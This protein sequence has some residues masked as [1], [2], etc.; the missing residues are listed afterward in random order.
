MGIL[1]RSDGRVRAWWRVAF[2]VL[3]IGAAGMVASSVV[4]GVLALTP[5]VGLARQYGVPLADFSEVLVLLIATYAALR[6]VDGA[7]DRTWARVG[8]DL[9]GLR[10]RLLLIGLAAGSLAILVP[11][12]VL[13]AAGRLGFERQPAEIASWWTAARGAFVVLLP[14]AFAEELA[15]RGYLL[16]TLI[17]GV[18]TPFAVA[19]TSVLFAVLH[20]LNPDPT[21]LSV[22]MVALA[23]V[24]LAAIRLTTGSLWAAWIGHLAWNLVQA[25]MLHAPVSGLPLPTPG[26]RLEDHGPAWLTGGSWGPE[27]GLAAAAGMLVAT[28]LLVRWHGGRSGPDGKEPTGLTTQA[29]QNG[30]RTHD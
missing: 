12:G 2:F 21:F 22:G 11:C 13:L 23:G 19:I 14:A 17:D 26:Y 10:I 15:L 1:L 4:Y 28:F 18:G 6:V 29:V 27:G 24:F 30:D 3:A 25:V 8:L 7:R 5:I 20:L 9:K 16:T